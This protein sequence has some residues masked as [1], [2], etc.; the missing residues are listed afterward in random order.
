MDLEEAR[1][2]S[3]SAGSGRRDCCDGLRSPA[4]KYKPRSELGPPSTQNLSVRAEDE[5]RLG[6]VLS[7]EIAGGGGFPFAVFQ[8]PPK[9]LR[10]CHGARVFEI[11]RQTNITIR[12][13]QQHPKSA[14]SACWDDWM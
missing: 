7:V 8:S 9:D 4:I 3:E 10:P 1:V 5:S 13:A 14:S 12:K 6:G 11:H 2:R